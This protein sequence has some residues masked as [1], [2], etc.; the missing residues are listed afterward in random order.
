MNRRL[1]WIAVSLLVVVVS[2]IGDAMR[3]QTAP[4][5]F[6]CKAFSA[7]TTAADLRRKFGPANVKR[8]RVPWGGAEGDVSDGTVLFGNDPTAKLEI[9]WRDGVNQR[10]PGWIS[11][12]GE[13]TRWQSPAGITLGTS[14][15]MVEQLNGR[16]FRLIGFGTDVQGTVMSWSGGKLEAQNISGCR[17]RV[18]LGLEWKNLDTKTRALVNQVQGESEFSSGHRSMQSLDPTVNELFLQYDSDRLP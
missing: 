18:R 14:L 10:D 4:L 9:S 11:V 12:R 2:S 16:A 13:H 1:S 6:S 17:L 15:R 7:R 5:E 8:A 3:A